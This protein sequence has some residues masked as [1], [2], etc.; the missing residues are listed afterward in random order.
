MNIT[1][2]A[3]FRAD[4]ARWDDARTLAD[5]GELTALWLLHDGVIYHPGYGDWEG[6]PGPDQ[7]TAEI[8]GPLA[9]ANRAGY[10]TDCSQPGRIHERGWDGSWW[11]Q[12]AA[13]TGYATIPTRDR[14]RAR[15][16]NQ[17]I[18]IDRPLRILPWGKWRHVTPVTWRNKEEHTWFGHRFAILDILREYNSR[19]WRLNMRLARARQITIIDPKPCRNT[20]LWPLL[21]E[22][23]DSTETG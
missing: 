22:F 19:S 21:A 6:D 20:L 1:D 18:V 9:A 5:L 10:V 17:L 13:V 16:D 7:E 23:G 15:M 14:L 2:R 4:V 11:D 3:Q 8:V 12:R